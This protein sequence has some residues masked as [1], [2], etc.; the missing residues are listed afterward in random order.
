MTIY[1]H[2]SRWEREITKSRRNQPAPLAASAGDVLNVT[3]GTHAGSTAT[4]ERVMEDGYGV[5]FAD[6]SRAWIDGRHVTR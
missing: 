5:L 4:V 1:N 3:A 2:A 6:G